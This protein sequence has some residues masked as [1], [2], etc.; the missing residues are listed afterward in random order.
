VATKT[1]SSLE[2][3]QEAQLRPIADIAAA[4]GLEADE[5]D[6]RGM[7]EELTEES[8]SYARRRVP[9]VLEVEDGIRVR[10]NEGLL[11]SIAGNLIGNA[12]E[13]S[14]EA[15]EVRVRATA[16]RGAVE[17]EISNPAPE[18]APQDVERLFEPFWRK[19]GGG[20]SS[21]HAGIGLTLTRALARA[22]ELDLQAE[23]APDGRLSMRL[24]GLLRTSS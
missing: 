12:L 10:T 14:P 7:L 4:A 19:D 15:S 13:Y 18:L 6:L 9:C 16:D 11:R 2:I 21:A 23:L 3:A 8:S 20:S 24:T 1:P 5:V 17:L 22:L